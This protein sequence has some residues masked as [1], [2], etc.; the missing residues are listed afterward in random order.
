MQPQ[1]KNGLCLHSRK[2]IIADAYVVEDRL[3]LRSCALK[4]YE[5]SF[6]DLPALASIMEED[7][8]NFEID[9]DGSFIHWPDADIHLDLDAVVY[10]TDPA[11]KK[12][13]KVDGRSVYEA[14]GLKVGLFNASETA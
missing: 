10:A 2:P 14:N 7:R 6:K 5:V 8:P 9:S 11:A 3:L 12:R 13:M 1:I 4:T